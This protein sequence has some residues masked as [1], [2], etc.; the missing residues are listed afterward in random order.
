MD[1]EVIKISILGIIG[2]SLIGLLIVEITKYNWNKLQYSM[3]SK[4]DEHSIDQF[5]NILHDKID[6]NSIELSEIDY[7]KIIES[8]ELTIALNAIFNFFENVGYAYNRN[9]IDKKYAE[10]CYSD[11]IIT[12]FTKYKKII[13]ES[14]VKYNDSRILNELEKMYNRMEINRTK[15]TMKTKEKNA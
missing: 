3:S 7:T 14:R 8:K 4:W 6:F 9:I 10:N 11:P 15:N 2:F 13:S 1:I 12:V 5:Y